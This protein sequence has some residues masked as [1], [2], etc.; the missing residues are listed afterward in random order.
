MH[1]NPAILYFFALNKSKTIP[2]HYSS[3][4]IEI[5]IRSKEIAE[6]L[7]ISVNTVNNHRKNLMDKLGVSNSS[8]AVSLTKSLGII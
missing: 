1:R 5:G 4:I 3:P 8:E 7:F 2:F 6:Q